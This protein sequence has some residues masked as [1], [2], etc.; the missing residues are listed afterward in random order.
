MRSKRGSFSLATLA[1][2]SIFEVFVQE[3]PGLGFSGTWGRVGTTGTEAARAGGDFRNHLGGHHHFID[4]DNYY[5]D[6]S[7]SYELV[8]HR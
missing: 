7:A 5:L 1:R 6:L 2:E 3:G 4:N 8:V